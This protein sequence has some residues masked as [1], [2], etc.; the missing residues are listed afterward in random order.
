MFEN[1]NIR[2]IKLDIEQSNK[3]SILVAESWGYTL[4]EEDF[5]SRIFLVKMY[6]IKEGSC[7]ILKEEN[8]NGVDKMDDF[9]V[10]IF[11]ANEDELLAIVSEK[12]MLLESQSVMGRDIIIPN[13]RFDDYQSYYL[14][15]IKNDVKIY[16]SMG[17]ADSICYTLGTHDY[18]LE[19]VKE[20]KKQNIK[21]KTDILKF[22]SSFL[23]GYFGLFCG[24]DDREQYI[25]SLGGYISIDSFKGKGLAA[26]SERAALANNILELFGIKSIYVTGMVNGE[27]HA[28]NIIVNK[29]GVYHILDTSYNCSLYDENNKVIGNV[30]SMFELGSFDDSLKKFLFEG[31]ERKFDDGVAIKRNDGTVIFR[32]N[33]E[34]REYSI[35]P[36]KLEDIKT[37]SR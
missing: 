30:T 17:Y 24:V 34:V 36:I 18:L 10:K 27:Q 25:G 37:R 20:I 26:C 6:Y 5:E 13:E 12:V 29:K 33:G 1:Y 8:N 11:N 19:F 2:S 14:G 31:E 16:P 15:F 23:D 3:N 4:D 28:F 21:N 9:L 32:R 7:Y 35:E 22:L